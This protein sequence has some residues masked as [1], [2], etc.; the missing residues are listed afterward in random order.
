MKDIENL[1][2]EPARQLPVQS[3]YDVVV[4]GGGIAG[5]AA[6]V[7]AAR[8]GVSVCLLEKENGLGGLATLGNVI[9]WLPL[10]NG[11]G[12]QVIGGIGEEMLRLSVR[13]LQAENAEAD[14]HGVPPCWEKGGDKKKRLEARFLTCFNPA[15]Y[16][17]ALENW[18]L[19]NGV[20]VMYDTRLCAVR[21]R[22]GAITHV[23]VEN[24]SGRS[25]IACG[26]AVDASGDADLCYL[27]G[28]ETFTSDANVAAG[29]FYYLKNGVT[30][31][32]ESS[33]AFRADL[34][35]TQ[36]KTPH[37]R[38]DIA[39]Q[40]TAQLIETRKLTA[41]VLDGLRKENPGVAIEPFALPSIPCFRATR[42][43]VGEQSLCEGDMYQWY[44]D[45]VGLTGDWRRR[46]P[47]FPITLRML[48]GVA[49]KNLLSA[50]RC[51]SIDNTAWDAARCIPTCA[52]SGEAAGLAAA[53]AVKEKGG[54]AH[55]IPVRSFQT[56]M[57]KN[58]NILGPRF[59][60]ES[61]D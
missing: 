15:S 58:G 1:I 55:R 45:T 30:H 33:E 14:F 8:A 21:R 52:I 20:H 47:V 11:K 50:G 5:V 38:G 32:C 24:K 12:R 19:E 17:L 56:L 54:N 51:F 4:V 16:I 22:R 3:A 34:D 9:V 27:A 42:R 10:C 29:W 18:I 46:G 7:A 48:R 53:V 39:E 36:I 37:Y 60:A 6:A 13:D 44:K 31:L 26:A 59:V 61:A 49:N 40:V 35:S 28:E 41:R 23:I 2:S 25:A 43:L 57:R